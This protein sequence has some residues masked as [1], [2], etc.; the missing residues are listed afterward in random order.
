[1]LGG[2]FL[3]NADLTDALNEITGRNLRKVYVPGGVIRGDA[4]G[5]TLKSNSQDLQITSV[6]FSSDGSDYT[7]TMLVNVPDGVAG[8]TI[9]VTPGGISK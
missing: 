6:S 8:K 9:T 3:N 7:L 1:M 4:N 5:G 2:N